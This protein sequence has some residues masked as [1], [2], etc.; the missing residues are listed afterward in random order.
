MIFLVYFLPF[1]LFQMSYN[2]HMFLF[3][4][5]KDLFIFRV[6][7]REAERER[8][9]HRCER[10]TSI[11]C[12][13]FIRA[14]SETEPATQ[15]C[16]LSRNWTCDLLLCGAMLNQLS[17]TGQGIHLFIYLLLKYILLIMLLPLSHSP[18]FYSPLPCIRHPTCI[19]LRLVSCPWVVHISSSTSSCPALFLTSPCVFSTDHLCF[20]FPVDFPPFSPL[21][22][23]ADN[24]PRDIHF[25]ISF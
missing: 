9:K 17:H 10:E 19:P 8:E 20:L 7:G 13:S 6:R 3:F 4:S 1:Y 25:Y 14:L 15:A 22:I 12:L 2:K 5:K 21:P 24:P 23:P 18:P 11:G 16:A